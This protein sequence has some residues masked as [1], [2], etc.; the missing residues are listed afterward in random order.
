MKTWVVEWVKKVIEARKAAERPGPC[1]ECGTRDPSLMLPGAAY[2]RRCGC[3]TPEALDAFRRL[4]ADGRK[5]RGL[6]RLK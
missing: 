2:C 1:R 3:V 6:Y 5:G 4:W